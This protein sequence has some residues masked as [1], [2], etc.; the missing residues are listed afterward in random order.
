MGLLAKE[1]SEEE[2]WILEQIQAGCKAAKWG[3]LLEWAFRTL[4]GAA[5]W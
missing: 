4:A 2:T 5:G 1:W 3:E